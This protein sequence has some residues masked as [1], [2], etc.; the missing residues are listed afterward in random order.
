LQSGKS[1]HAFTEEGFL[2][3]PTY[4][5]SGKLPFAAYK[6][7]NRTGHSVPWCVIVLRIDCKYQ[8]SKKQQSVKLHEKSIVDLLTGGQTP[9]YRSRDRAFAA[10]SNVGKHAFFLSKIGSPTGM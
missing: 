2:L 7:T 1:S 10:Y 4:Y 8:T 5:K 3:R 6:L 9:D